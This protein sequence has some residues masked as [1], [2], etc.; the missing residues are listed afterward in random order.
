MPMR[1]YT[2]EWLVPIISPPVRDGAV[3]VEGNQI[4]FVGS[5]NEAQSRPEYSEAETLSF[6]RAAIMPGFVNAHTHLELTLMRGFLEDLAFCDWIR[7]LT[8]AR[9]ERLTID[10]LKS[11][12]LLGAAEAI[13]A[14]ITTLAD[15]GDS[16]APFDAL[17]QSGL[18][19]IAF[20]E[21]FGPAVADAGNNLEELKARVEEMRSRE[22]ELARVGVSPHAPYSVSGELFQLVAEYASGSALDV[23]IHA[24]ESE[25]EQ[26]MMIEGAGEFADGLRKRGITWR[27]PGTSTIK[28]LDSVGVLQ[29]RP[30]LVHCVRASDEDIALMA[31]RGARAAHCPKSNAKLGHGIAPLASM[32]GAGVAVGLGT[33][34]AASNNR[35]DMIDETRFCALVHRAASRDFKHPGAEQALRLATI[36]GARA[37]GLDRVIGSLE[38]GKQADIIAVDLSRTHNTPVDDPVASIVFSALTTDVVFTAVS[39]RV[40]FDHSGVKTIDEPAIQSRVNDSRKRLHSS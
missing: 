8:G 17:I 29:A 25:A 1:I 5:K 32:L 20:R 16:S 28:Y 27:A 23:C 36:D 40:L 12:A 13:R 2:A 35:L 10:D 21:V 9:R 31:R 24:A 14:G 4:K 7:K 19:G 6:G 3:V 33:D 37:L 34:S 38:A 26:Q 11:S 15:T 39:G 18:R 30:L 22:T